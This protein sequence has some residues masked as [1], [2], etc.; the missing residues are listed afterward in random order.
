MPLVWVVRWDTDPQV[1]GRDQLLGVFTDE[2]VARQLADEVNAF[3]S[4]DWDEKV[5]IDEVP[6][7]PTREELPG[8]WMV[9]V[10]ETSKVLRHHRSDC[11][12]AAEPAYRKQERKKA[13][14]SPMMG[15]LLPF[16]KPDWVP[17]WEF[18]GFGLTFRVAREAALAERE[19]WAAEQ[20]D[21]KV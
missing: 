13:H 7:N 10:S 1:G 8:A 17:A 2:A 20:T 6:L 16:N 21:A 19:R 12:C 5:R 18:T 4:G 9:T 11:A 14:I 3:N 15:S